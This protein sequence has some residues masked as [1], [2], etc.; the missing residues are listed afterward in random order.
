[1]FATPLTS[2]SD[3]M[4]RT[5]SAALQHALCWFHHSLLLD[6]Q[7]YVAAFVPDCPTCVHTA[8]AVGF[9]ICEQGSSARF[10]AWLAGFNIRAIISKGDVEVYTDVCGGV[11]GKHHT[12]KWRTPTLPCLESCAMYV[13]V[14]LN[15]SC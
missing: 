9:L 5:C 6:L 2:T 13:R 11:P 3:F 7:L 1:M 8:V 12:G 10:F 4:Q 15:V 14:E